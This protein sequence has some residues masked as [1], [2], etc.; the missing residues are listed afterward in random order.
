MHIFHKVK[1]VLY[2]YEFNNIFMFA[3]SVA[4]FTIEK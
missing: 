4:I 3:L 1:C 2:T